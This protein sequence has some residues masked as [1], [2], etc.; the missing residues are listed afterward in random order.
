MADHFGSVRVASG[1]IIATVFLLALEAC[2]TTYLEQRADQP[3]NAADIMRAADLQPQF[4]QPTGTVDTGGSK[5]KS[6]SFFGSSTPAPLAPAPSGSTEV[7]ASAE[8]YTLNFDNAPVA[9]VAKSVLGDVLGVGYVI[10]PRAQGS[11]TLSSGRPVA[12]KDMLFVLENALHANNLNM[13]RDASGYRIVPANEGAIG[14]VDRAGGSADVEPG[15]GMT[16]IPLQYV[17]GTTLSKLLEGF[18]ARPG[19]IRTDPSGK[20]LI[21]VGTGSE[22][23]SALDTVRSFDVDW[24]KGQSVGMYPSKTALPNPSSANWKR[25]WTRAIQASAMVS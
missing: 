14:A 1:R 21:V 4:P 23:Q 7:E 15:Y 2:T 18:A 6:F 17:S 24:L 9:N 16:V 3:Q 25:S 5:P 12:K 10:D 22:R 13:A 19:A 8:G 11:I 20:L